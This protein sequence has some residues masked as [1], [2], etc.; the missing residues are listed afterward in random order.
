MALSV[1]SDP[2]DGAHRVQA[3][4]LQVTAGGLGQVLADGRLHLG[5]LGPDLD[6]QALARRRAERLDLGVA[7]GDPVVLQ[8]GRDLILGDRGG[9]HLPGHATFEVDAVVQAAPGQRD[10]RQHDQQAG[11]GEADPP[12]ADEVEGRLAVVEP[13]PEAGPLGL[14]RRRGRRSRER[15]RHFGCSHEDLLVDGGLT[16]GDTEHLVLAGVEARARQQDDRGPGEEVGDDDVEQGRQAEEE[17]E[18]PDRPDGQ[19]P[20]DA[21]A[22]Q[23][24]DV[25]RQDGAVG[26]REALGRTPTAATCPPAR[27]P[28]GARSTRRR[29]RP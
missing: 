5:G 12:L 16:R 19:P 8:D 1:I 10:Q 13:V 28:S 7:G 20:E 18:A 27:R 29:S 11:D 4:V 21:G 26:R 15:V 23:R 9:V 17:G 25:G 14:A 24:H 3:H 22:D 2:H 6:A